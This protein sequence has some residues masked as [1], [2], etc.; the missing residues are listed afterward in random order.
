MFGDE[1]KRVHFDLMFRSI[2][3]SAKY[4]VVNNDVKIVKFTF[5]KR[6]WKI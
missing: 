6:F 1:C 5:K 4:N 2:R 3:K